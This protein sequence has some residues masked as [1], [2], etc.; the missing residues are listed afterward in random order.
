[1]NEGMNVVFMILLVIKKKT[2]GGGMTKMGSV[3]IKVQLIT[4]LY[5]FY[6]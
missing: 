6:H 2:K 3:N 4:S 1:M 5:S